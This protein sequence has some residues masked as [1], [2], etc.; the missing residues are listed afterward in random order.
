M[1]K[2]KSDQDGSSPGLRGG[3]VLVVGVGGLGSPA[4]FA[5][6]VAGV[7]TI[8][9]V[10]SDIVEL[11]NLHRQILHLTTDV[12][13]AKV[14]SAREKLKR[15]R[16]DVEIVVHHERLSADNLADLFRAY[17]FIVDAT[18]GV[19]TKF[20]INDGAILLNK[21]FSHAGVVRFQGQ[22]LT[23]LP[24]QT[25]CLRCL[26]PIPPDPEDNISCQEAGIL[27]SLAGSIG[28]IQAAEAARY[29]SGEGSRLG[30]RLLTCDALQ[31]R[32]RT[33]RLTRSS[34]CPVCGPNPT[35]TRLRK[36]SYEAD[37]LCLPV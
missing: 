9:L 22:V 18:D 31:A 35:I 26:F 4:A 8:G 1:N 3:K 32:W 15:M 20:L 7:G 10:D 37:R 25:T 11:S 16:G 13:V 23:V 19:G 36:E 24:G 27:G 21:P 30:D 14:I 2:R 6:A 33:I 12:G 17:D 5:L 28:C 29:I 34:R